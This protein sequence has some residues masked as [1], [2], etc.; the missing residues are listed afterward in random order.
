MNHNPIL[1]STSC[2]ICGTTNYSTELY[3]ANFSIKDFNP[4]IFSARRIPDKIH[5][6]IV[7]C[8]SCGLVRSDPVIDQETLA[9]LYTKSSQTYDD[10]VPNLMESYAR[11]L[12]QTF[13]RL[14]GAGSFGSRKGSLLEIGCGSGFFLEKALDYGFE[15]VMGIEPS[16]QAVE[17]SSPRTRHNIICDILR[18]GLL[19]PEQFDIICMFQVFDH[20]AAPDIFLEE[21]KKALKPGGGILCLNH[22]VAA[23]SARL[24]GE[25]SPIFDIEHTFLYSKV[26]IRKVFVDSG[27]TVREVGS[28][29]NTY[30]LRYLIQL[31]PLPKGLKESIFSIFRSH[32]FGSI[33]LPIRLGNLFLIAQKL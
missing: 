33:K 19:Q 23:L 25:N 7:R 10:E 21:C 12:D 20:I 13:R 6:R 3:P 18:P 11:Y 16:Q 4:E 1:V 27:F 24:L 2:A 9:E 14:N 5:Y 30:S 28:V 22:N 32:L 31:L 15:Q 26:T 8:L 29:V 17:K